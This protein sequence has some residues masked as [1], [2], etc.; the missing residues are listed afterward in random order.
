[1]SLQTVESWLLPPRQPSP[2]QRGSALLFETSPGTNLGLASTSSA[3][4][5]LTCLGPLGWW[6]EGFALP[7]DNPLF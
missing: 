3:S 5:R 6:C 1:M 7:A 2:P 4:A